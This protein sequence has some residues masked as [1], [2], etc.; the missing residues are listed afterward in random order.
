[1]HLLEFNRIKKFFDLFVDLIGLFDQQM[2][3]KYHIQKQSTSSTLFAHQLRHA[4]KYGVI[5]F[6]LVFGTVFA[7]DGY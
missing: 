5:K 1:M 2:L 4:R 3:Y 7:T 6:Q